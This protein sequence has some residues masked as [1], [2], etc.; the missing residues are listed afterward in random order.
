MTRAMMDR[1]RW[2]LT[3]GAI[4]AIGLMLRILGARGGLWLDEA[5]SAIYADQVGTPL[6][7]I[8]HINHDN[9]HHL[10]SMWLQLV[11]LDAPPLLQ[12]ALSIVTGTLAILLAGLLGARRAP[13]LGLIT[14]ALFALSP[15]LV[16]LGSEARGYA[17][18]SVLFLTA[19]LL[20]DRW[21]AGEA[22]DSPTIP[23][24]ACFLVGA[25]CHLS[26]IF[27]FLAL[28]GW[29]IAILW[30]RDGIASALRQTLR[31]FLP[32]AIAIAAVMALFWHA[33]ATNPKGFEFGGWQPFTWPMYRLGLTDMAGYTFGAPALHQAWLILVPALL[34]AALVLRVTRAPFHLLVI[35]AFPLAVAI[36][37]PA[38]ISMARYYLLVTF[39]LLILFAE[40]AWRAWQAGG[41]PRRLAALALALFALGSTLT[42]LDLFA[43]RRADPGA[44]IRALQ[45]RAPTGARIV[46]P[47]DPGLPQLITAAASA[48]YPLRIAPRDRQCPPARFIFV[49]RF[50]W[51]K[52]PTEQRRCGKRYTPIASAKARG[53]SGTD[54]ALFEVE[55]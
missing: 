13:A 2:W 44:A 9:N 3:I 6:G 49:D 33:A 15:M 54:W 22:K 37:Q 45:V 11:G 50:Y 14:A 26:I 16:T 43:N 31:L 12:R 40:T 29:T 55:R 35:L 25:F 30:Q 17:P 5:V 21:L 8:L 4:A 34:A 18:L 19:M 1:R 53:L 24:T 7:V 48:R 28:A 38:N 23:L 39:A 32:G 42:N 52:L 47:R 20:L 36:L 46:V 27:I 51:E 41:W 10:N